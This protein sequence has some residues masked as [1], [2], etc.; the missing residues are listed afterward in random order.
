M[1]RYATKEELGRVNVLREMV[2]ELHSSGRPDIFKPVFSQE[3]QDLVSI[4]WETD[5][6][7]VIVVLRDDVICGYACVDY[8]DR[9][10]AIYCFARRFYHINEFGVDESYRRQGVATELF[11]F[12]KAEA[13]AKGFDKIELDVWSFNDDALKFYESLGF[14]TYKRFME[15]TI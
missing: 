7:D 9:P 2:N 8:V 3:L 13:S 14:T 1:V 12:L 11:D 6:G 5:R 4:L 10:E 15:F